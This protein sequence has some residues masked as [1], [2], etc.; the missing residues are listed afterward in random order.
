[1]DWVGS[2][3]ESRSGTIRY[4]DLPIPAAKYVARRLLQYFS[5]V[6]I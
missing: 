4:R 6:R 3:E 5:T 1:M 2:E